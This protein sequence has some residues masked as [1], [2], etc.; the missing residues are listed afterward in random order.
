M[1]NNIDTL[2]ERTIK[3]LFNFYEKFKTVKPC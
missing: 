3:Q 2:E 1:F